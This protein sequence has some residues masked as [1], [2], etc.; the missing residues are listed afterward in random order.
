M[1]IWR[2][3]LLKRMIRM[4]AV[5]EFQ[6]IL[7]ADSGQKA[8]KSVPA[9]FEDLRLDYLMNIIENQT[10]GYSIRPFYYT[11]P[12][13][14][15]LIEYRQ[16]VCRDLSDKALYTSI[17]RFCSRLQK[18]RRSHA[19]SLQC[20]EAVQAASYHLAAASLYWES[21]VA[22]DRELDSCSLSSEGI[23]A[24]RE[25]VRKHIANL[26]G[27]KFEQ[28][29]AHAGEF[30]SRM[31]FRLA[32]EPERIVVAEETEE[33]GDYL[34]E[35]SEI[36][37]FQ[38]EEWDSAFGG[39]FPNA[40][41]PSYLEETLIKLLKKSNS[42]IFR[43]I[44]SFKQEFPDFYSEELLRFEEEVQFYISF[45]EF[46][47]KTR[48]FGYPVE[49]PQISGRNEF[50]G[51]G[52]YDLA[53]LWKNASRAYTV[54]SNDFNWSGRPSFFVVTGPNQGGKT[55]F[56]RSMGQAV[57]FAMMGLPAN[58]SSLKLPFFEGIATHFEA[59]E[60][61]QSNSGK[62][63]EEINR[64]APMM[65]QDKKHQFVILN[66]LFTT[67]TTYDALIMGKKV[68]EHFLKRDCYG[69]YVTHIQELAEETDSIISLVA[70]VEDGEDL[71]RTYRMIP[72]KAQ[73]YGYSDS[74][75]KQFELGYE[76]M[77]RRLS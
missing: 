70:Q 52:V 74:L 19:Y 25:Y 32:V 37:T 35:L 45:L 44:R 53:L 33:T 13:S 12:D 31:R 48:A 47:E 58:A 56:A 50:S 51:T 54:I 2:S 27:Q 49:I 55:T 21:L 60:K 6:S 71:R 46:A 3:R 17:R 7:F 40:L 8:G 14:V 4:E 76:D 11:L 64:L 39:I 61:I 24:L 26:Q 5:M 36:L 68:M 57:Y 34:K 9:F 22:F 62:L 42:D 73:G 72:M 66:E 18:S 29:V 59:E 77:I 1:T 63:K 41:E 10:K 75:V 69:I 67:A 28:A 65:H 23:L 15:S 30:F 16:Q 43:E 20:G 38:D